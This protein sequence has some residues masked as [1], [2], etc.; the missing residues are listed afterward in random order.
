MT[1]ITSPS[2]AHAAL[3]KQT[4]A[5]EA[6]LTAHT[7]SARKRVEEQ[8]ALLKD[9]EAKNV[10]MEADLKEKRTAFEKKVKKTYLVADMTLAIQVN[11]V[12]LSVGT[13]YSE[14]GLAAGGGSLVPGDHRASVRECYLILC[15]ADSFV[16]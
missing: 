12:M 8:V 1:S 11:M 2:P 9:L 14:Q 13:F 3:L 16:T 6:E 15:S 7:E 5:K 4:E 10:P